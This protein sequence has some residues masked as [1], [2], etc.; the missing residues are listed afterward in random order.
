MGLLAGVLVTAGATP[1]R[2]TEPI[3]PLPLQGG[4]L[5]STGAPV[6]VEVLPASAG[7]TSTLLL[8]DPEEVRIA[9]NRDVGSKTTIGPYA[10]GTE[11]VFGIRAG[12]QEFRLGPGTRNPDGIPHAIVDFDVDG[13]AVVGFEDLFGG[14]DRD[15]DDNI[16]KFCGGVAP[17]VPVEPHEPPN[18]DPVAPPVANAGPDQAVGEGSTVTLDASA[19]RASTKS[20]LQASKQQGTLPGGTA[21]RVD[22]AGLDRDASGLRVKGSL[23]LGQRP[24]SQNVS[25]VTKV[26]YTVDGGAPV[27]LSAQ[28]ALPKPGPATVDVAFDLPA[29]L[30]TGSHRICLTVTGT[31][32]AGTSTLTT[33][34]DLVTVTGEVSYSWRLASR[35]GPPVF[36]SS[37]TAARP[38]FLALDDGRYVFELTV[39]DGTGGTAADE[40]AVEVRNLAPTL[41]LTHGG[42]FAGGVTQ[43]NA[44]LTDEGWLDTHSAVVDW[45]DA[46]SSPVDVTIAGAGWGTFFG[47]HV[48]RQAGSF[49]VVVTLTDDDGGTTTQRIDHLEVTE[50]AAVWANS[51]ASRSLDWAGGSGVIQGRVHTNGELRFVGASKT[52]KG[53]STYAGS[54][55]ADTTRNSFTPPPVKSGVLG[56]PIN[57]QVADFRPGGPVAVE[58]GAAYH[59]MSALCSG[60]SWHDVQSTLASG[61][62]YASCDIKLNGS[63]IG[64]RVTLVSDGHIK[65]AGS[66]PAF[67][68]YRDGLLLLAG[69]PGTKAI[70]ISTSSS[71]FLGV[72]FAGS[73]QI[74][75]SGASNR[76]YCGI[77]SDTVAITGTDV[78]VRGADCGRPDQ[79]VSGP[80]VV[81]DLSAALTVDR[82]RA[83]PGDLLGYD[84][85]VTNRGTA[86]V[87]PS[88]IGLENVDTATARVAAHSF[89]VERQVAATGQWVP[90]ASLGDASMSVHVRPNPFEGVQY[91]AGGAVVGTTV[92]PGGWATWGVQAELRLTPAQIAELLDQ[93]RTT[94]VRTRVDFTL[95]PS[96][97]QARRLYTYGADFSAQLRAL[98]ADATGVAVTSILPDGDTAVITSAESDLNYR[99]APGASVTRHR[100]WTVPVPAPRAATETDAGY[101]SRLVALD[102]TELNGAAYAQATGGVGR[103]VAPLQRVTTT[104]E[105]PVV[106][107]STV[108]SAAIPAGASADYDLRL[109]H[110]GSAAA[111]ALEVKAAADTAPL[112]VTGAPTLLGAGELATARTTYA[113]P[114]GSTGSV[115]LRGTA[116]WKDARGNTY[117]LSGSDLAIER[118]LPAT[119]SASLDDALTVDVAGDG[120]VSPGD[121]VRYTL[122][123]ANR[124]GVALAGVTGRVPAPANTTLVSGSGATPD[125]GTLTLSGGEATFALPTIA[126]GTN[127]KVGFDVVVAQPFPAGV[128]RIETQGT[129]SATG[130][131][132]VVTDDPALPGLTD[133]TRTTITRPTPALTAAL[134]GHLVIDA[135]GSGGVTAGDTLAYDLTVSSVGTLP[136]T[137]VGVAVPAPAGTSVIADS[138]RTSQGTITTGSGVGIDLGTLAPSRQVTVAFRARLGSPLPAGT[139]TIRAQ[140]TLTSTELDPIPT[141]DPQTVEVGDATVIP[142]GGDGTNPQLPAT[143]V[144]GLSPAD[145]ARVATP[146]PVT[147]TITAPAPATIATWRVELT[148][149]TGGDPQVLASGTGSGLSADVSAKIDPTVLGNGLYVVFI[150][151]VT[152]DGTKTISTSSVIVDGSFKP[153]RLTTS[154]L[155]HQV[156][157]GGLPLQV[158]RSYDSFD[159]AAGDFGVGWKV[160]VADFRIG[161]AR[162][163]GQGG[164]A[165]HSTTCSLIF[166]DLEYTATTPHMVSVVWPDGH[167][168]VFDLKGVDGSTFFQGLARAKFVSHPGTDTTSTLEVAGDDSVF[169]NNGDL[170]AGAFGSGGVFD[171][172]VFKLTDRSGTVYLIDRRSGL[173]KVTDRNSNTLTFTRDGVKSSLGKDIAYTRDATDRITKI[174]SQAGTTS[175]GYDHGDL[176][177]STDLAGVVTRYEY[178]GAH[179]LINVT[180]SGGVSLGRSVYNDAGHLIAWID[181]E[182]NRS[183]I[184]T[185]LDENQERITDPTGR[186][187][188]VTTFNDGGD[189]VREDKIAGGQTLTTTWTYDAQHRMLTQTDPV[190]NTIT[191]TRDNSGL[192]RSRTD[193]AGR[194]W[195]LDY[196]A[197]SQPTAFQGPGG[198]GD[199]AWTYDARGNIVS[200]D[201]A[202]GPTVSMAYDGANLASIKRGGT[203]MASFTYKD[204]GAGVGLV[205]SVTDAHG[206]KTSVSYDEAGRVIAETDP[207]GTMTYKYDANGQPVERVNPAAGRRTWS[208]GDR[209]QL[210]AA[211]DELGKVTRY[212]YDDALRMVSRTDRNGDVT[213]YAHDA[214]GRVLRQ[215]SPGKVMTF[216]YDGLGRQV[217]AVNGDVTTQVA[218]DMASRM[219]SRVTTGPGLPRMEFTYTHC[220]CGA[221]KSVTGPGG[222]T[223]YDFDAASG[224]LANVI[225]PDGGSF[226]YTW[227][228]AGRLSK[229]TRPNQI[230]DVLAWNDQGRLASRTQVRADGTQVTGVGYG[231]DAGG[232]R[233]SATD[234]AGTHTFTYDAVG[235]LT[236]ADHPDGFAVADETFAY[237]KLGNRV[238]NVDN[239]AGTMV[240]DAANRLLRDAKSDYTYDGEGNLTS[241]KVRATGATTRFAWDADHRMVRLTK[242]T[243]ATVS[244]R[245][246]AFG[247]RVQATRS[248]DGRVTSWGYDREHV[249]AV[250]RNTGAGRELVQTFVTSPAGDPL[251]ARVNGSTLFPVLDGLGSVVGTLDGAGA[252]ASSTA[253]SAFGQPAGAGT[254]GVGDSYGYTGHAWDSDAGMHY[255][256]ARW[257][258]SGTG[259]FASEDPVDAVNLYIYVDNRPLSFTDPT[260][261]VAAG[262]Y[263]GISKDAPMRARMAS[264]GY[265]NQQ[266]KDAIRRAEEQLGRSFSKADRRKVHDEITG[267]GYEFWDIVEIALDLFG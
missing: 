41:K 202:A 212:S 236:G 78:S 169:F 29:G 160:D 100:E 76:F 238:S 180:G 225:S 136:V 81:P 229:I 28:L 237:D 197:W 149:A 227:D 215:V 23:T 116:G 26:A 191:V 173:Q 99:L 74:S 195:K 118:Q 22:I 131:T 214:A 127:R 223:T 112:P 210:L 97:V 33:C 24:T 65:I 142:I 104:R 36:L 20:A 140:G 150:I 135:D 226:G 79:T 185:D 255:A 219:T 77:L 190:G 111:S 132:T 137:G 54:L 201:P 267:Q 46:A 247:K 138:V 86:L 72:L 42:S 5:F 159:S 165:G 69:A 181:A 91:A 258:D 130:L 82:Q 265:Q 110:L 8:L 251:Q 52:V 158:I 242:A 75:I 261:M 228:P 39:T 114:V 64:G 121:T 115:V 146:T 263:G 231:Y 253:Y 107:I 60:G 25:S 230:S 189:K 176:V 224:Q 73:G 43:V 151:S 194:T 244:Y 45:G 204:S 87:V 83:L 254:V 168:E 47:S 129:V 167:Q 209:G 51:T 63:Q 178:D 19:S 7:L 186:L 211:T 113:A 174:V 89:T 66:R 259:R 109:A 239:A 58:V 163:L 256:R 203:T 48:Y 199:Y 105:L 155:D 207:N 88:L 101:L 213:T 250:W 16:F 179:N 95:D 106:G 34:S 200:A 234:D 4:Q 184:A 162:P 233:T 153:G 10:S 222:T 205:E 182:G 124:G 235:N 206:K 220:E 62:Y 59:D 262:E 246:D 14:G 249:A 37:A 248:S 171:P 144:S 172:T 161:R 240:Y 6:T 198:V 12:G 134:T 108:G 264:N 49:D 93:A 243:G 257:Y 141:D 17:E 70:D 122:T 183:E 94:G 216:A 117:G 266:F 92:A 217:E 53:R 67:E 218:Y 147:A 18:P 57:P 148:S 164:W 32:A 245:D 80:V 123:I 61:V 40:V 21:F 157:L 50:P 30:A 196:N 170:R 193:A 128:A 15:Y 156:G 208:Y 71:K 84:V 260:G 192:I 139:T 68:P 120:A 56:F 102:G 1:A 9:T 177:S 3:D 241:L 143:S 96:T 119:L 85:T 13:C 55:S 221:V 125:G 145:G 44:T 152:S 188:T 252:L 35:Q 2:A 11:L 166:C 98:G 103:L 187:T 133:P 90:V 232:R 27:D 154:F 38:T 31:D 175:Y 126:G